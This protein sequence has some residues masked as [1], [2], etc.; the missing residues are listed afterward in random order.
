MATILS[1]NLKVKN[2]QIIKVQNDNRKTFSNEAKF[3]YALW[4]KLESGVETCTMFTK[5]EFDKCEKALGTFDNAFKLGHLY[6]IQKVKAAKYGKRFFCKV[7]HE[8]TDET[9][10]VLTETLLDTVI[11]RALKNIED[12]PE[13]AWLTNLID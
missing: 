9:C 2:G 7:I 8:N 3:Y 5:S 12:Q 10:L 11:N 13:K 6:S 4:V 1:K